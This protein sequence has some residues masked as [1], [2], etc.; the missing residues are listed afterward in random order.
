MRSPFSF[1]V[2]FPIR[3]RMLPLP[4]HR[5]TLH[6]LFTGKGTDLG[7]VTVTPVVEATGYSKLSM[8]PSSRWLPNE[9][10]ESR[11]PWE[12]GIL[13][14]THQQH[15]RAPP[16]EAGREIGAVVG[17]QSLILLAIRTKRRR[18]RSRTMATKWRRRCRQTEFSMVTTTTSLLSIDFL[19][20]YRYVRT[21]RYSIYGIKF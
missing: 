13:S 1:P 6:L 7:P 20:M 18:R 10:S 15:R 16:N 17:P 14:P 21:G 11:V 19:D 12:E 8:L 5:Q 3:T 9:P 2:L 4:L